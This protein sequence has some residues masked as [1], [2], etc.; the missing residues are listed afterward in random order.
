MRT[1]DILRKVKKL[2][3][4]GWTKGTYARKKNG[5]STNPKDSEAVEF[6]SIGAFHRVSHEEDLTWEHKN[7]AMELFRGSLPNWAW[8]NIVSFNNHLNTTKQDVI[9]VLEKAANPRKGG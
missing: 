6:C 5:I 9:K 8:R 2:I 1:R 4:E 7:K 3:Q